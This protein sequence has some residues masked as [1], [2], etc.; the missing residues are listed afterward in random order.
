MCDMSRRREYRW[1]YLWLFS[2]FSCLVLLLLSHTFMSHICI[3]PGT[4]VADRKALQQPSEMA[5]PKAPNLV[6]EYMNQYF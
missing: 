3:H 1:A 4:P 2:F 5:S 6:D